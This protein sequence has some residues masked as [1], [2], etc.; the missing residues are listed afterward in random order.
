[1]GRREQV[2]PAPG[3]FSFPEI[4]RAVRCIEPVFDELPVPTAPVEQDALDDVRN[5]VLKPSTHSASVN[6][7]PAPTK[8]SINIRLLNPFNHGKLQAT[9]NDLKAAFALTK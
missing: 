6:G 7:D 3:F 1:M 5:E 8:M 2:C 4:E 9:H